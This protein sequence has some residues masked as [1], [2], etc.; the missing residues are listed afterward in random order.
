MYVSFGCAKNLAN[1]RFLLVYIIV[2]TLFHISL[3][4]AYH[5]TKVLVSCAR[6]QLEIIHGQHIVNNRSQRLME[7]GRRWCFTVL[8]VV[9]FVWLLMLILSVTVMGIATSPPVA[10]RIG[11]RL[12][13]PCNMTTITLDSK[14][15]VANSSSYDWGAMDEVCR[16]LAMYPVEMFYEESWTYNACLTADQV[17]TEIWRPNVLSVLVWGENGHMEVMKLV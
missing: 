3:N 4:V 15:Y 7:G 8:V 6:E 13:S 9:V 16:A 2:V 11:D 14:S 10:I 12:Y 17:Q 1:S 5:G